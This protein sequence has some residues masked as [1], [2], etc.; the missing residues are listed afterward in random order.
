MIVVKLHSGLGNQLFQYALGRNLALKYQT[1]LILDIERFSRDNLRDYKLK[2]FHT[3]GKVVDNYLSAKFLLRD[4]VYYLKAKTTRWQSVNDKVWEPTEIEEIPDNSILRG[5]WPSEEYFKNIR[6]L[7][8]AEF[9]LRADYK[10]A[11][12]AT[13]EKRIKETQSVALHF[14]RGDYLHAENKDIFGLLGLHYYERAMRHMHEKVANPHYFIFSDDISWVK[15]NFNL[16]NSYEFVSDPALLQD[17]QEFSLM[18]A[19]KHHIIANS[20]FS[21]WA[22][23]LNSN[24]HKIVIQPETWYLEAKAQYAYEKGYVLKG[25]GFIRL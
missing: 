15:E 17:V 11:Q 6:E 12:Y 7:L 25:Q 10:D 3:C 1:K 9:E 14:R 22:A 4:P 24:P 21:W 23:W 8:L 16:P 19:C 2:Y 5:Y 20:T 13:V 18:R